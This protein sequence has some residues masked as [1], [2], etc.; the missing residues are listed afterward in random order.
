[1]ILCSRCIIRMVLLC[2][3]WSCVMK[4]VSVHLWFIYRTKTHE[5]RVFVSNPVKSKRPD[6]QRNIVYSCYCVQARILRSMS[7]MLVWFWSM[8]RSLLFLR[9]SANSSWFLCSIFC[10]S[11]RGSVQVLLDLIS[12]NLLVKSRGSVVSLSML[13]WGKGKPLKFEMCL[14]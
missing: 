7:G 10:N 4:K 14:L 13:H 6:L 1:M 2:M 5:I 9:K 11:C 8:C 3:I 12:L